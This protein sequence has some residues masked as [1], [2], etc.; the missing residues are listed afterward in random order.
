MIV[1][2]NNA[3]KIH[4]ISSSQEGLIEA[5]FIYFQAS[6]A[7]IQGWTNCLRLANSDVTNL[8]KPLTIRIIFTA[9]SVFL[10]RSLKQKK[11]DSSQNLLYILNIHAVKNAQRFALKSIKII[12][13]SRHRTSVREYLNY[14]CGGFCGR[15]S[16]FIK[17]PFFALTYQCWLSLWFPSLCIRAPFE[18]KFINLKE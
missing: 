18:R 1:I 10:Q 16:R 2:I 15:F 14:T 4:I 11:R 12:S 17:F 13:T 9:T 8:S 7:S 3:W 5:N 6:V